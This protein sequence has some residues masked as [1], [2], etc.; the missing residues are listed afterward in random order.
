M[1]NCNGLC[2]ILYTGNGGFLLTLNPDGTITFATDDGSGY[3]LLN[4]EVTD[5]VNGLWHHIAAV[6]DDV[7]GYIYV[8]GKAISTTPVGNKLPPLNVDN[9]IRLL[10][11]AVDQNQQPHQHF[12]GVLG[13]IR[14]WNVARSLTDIL[15]TMERKLTGSEHGLVG[16]WP[17]DLGVK[18]DFS[19]TRN[20]VK[21]PG[22]MITM[23]APPLTVPSG[24]LVTLLFAGR[25][26]TGTMYGGTHGT[27]KNGPLLYLTN[28]DYVIFNNAVIRN[29]I[30]NGNS[31]SWDWEGNSSAAEFRFSLGSTS[32]YY[33]PE[34]NVKDNIF[35]GWV[36]LN[37][38]EGKLDFRG[39]MLAP[40][41]PCSFIQSAQ[42]GLIID[43]GAATP[44]TNLTAQMMSS[45]THQH[46]CIS[47]DGKIIHMLSQLAIT[48][49]TVPPINGTSLVLQQP[50][51]GN[52]AQIWKFRADGHIETSLNSSFVMSLQSI[53]VGAKIVLSSKQGTVPSFTQLWYSLF[54]RQYIFNES[55]A[56]VVLDAG[57]SDTPGTNAICNTQKNTYDA[58]QLWYFA[59]GYIVCDRNGMVLTVKNGVATS[60]TEVVM[61]PL[62][63]QSS[64][65]TWTVDGNHIKCSLGNFVLDTSNSKIVISSPDST[66]NSQK[67]KLYD[68]VEDNRRSARSLHHA[69]P[70]EVH[71]TVSKDR[72]L[73]SSTTTRYEV[74]MITSNSWFAGT[75]NTVEIALSSVDQ[76]TE[77]VQLIN[78]TTHS[79]PFERGQS[80]TFIVELKSIGVL[81]GMF[82]SYGRN[83]YFGT[84]RWL[85]AGVKVYDPILQVVY[86]KDLGNHNVPFTSVIEFDRRQRVTGDKIAV[87]KYPATNYENIWDHTYAYLQS[88]HG[89]IYFDA[90]GGHE[91]SPLTADI[92]V[93]NATVNAAVKMT[94]GHNIDSA[95][96]LKNVYGH[97]DVAGKET[98]GI[99]ASGRLN[100]DGQCHNIINRLMYVANPEKSFDDIW[101]D[102][103]KVP[104]GY[105]LLRFVFGPYG[106]GFDQWCMQNGFPPPLN[107]NQ[108]L[109]G[110]IQRFGNAARDNINAIIYAVTNL[111]SAVNNNPDSN[112]EGSE[113]KD[114]VKAVHNSG[115]D[116]TTL[117][118]M[119]NLT[120][121]EIQHDEL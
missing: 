97:D 85:L 95:H 109:Y 18:L 117:A 52:Q 61:E 25:Y 94:T 69:L 24:E 71:E 58:G 103:E 7:N 8:D 113:V 12:S 1:M 21:A 66:I 37:R 59:G 68:P 86:T 120:E 96:P 14:I 121:E 91:G 62:R 48:V 75:D 90:A 110:Y 54:G 53:S 100:W 17:G 51:S 76:D 60:G 101:N 9:S 64:S 41:S 46:F 50:T 78:S 116:N 16:Y 4:S 115:V 106:V 79:N 98:C 33:W 57:S 36:Q 105:G 28:T 47:E 89:T 49:S 31:I 102:V 43:A 42:N 39:Q 26:Q 74:T 111:R 3:A 114:F 30:F 92:L 80:D 5:V 19:R 107:G 108:Q 63:P 93:S 88:S 87:C 11:G 112:P 45:D 99:R 77:L 67:W 22:V 23:N 104:R 2:Y 70:M 32:R 82:L 44:G 27:W 119:T 55:G 6:R 20:T 10:I 118:N 35:E 56:S 84:E 29:P 38:S 15:S 73:L 40:M 34:A 72:N 65:Q 13:E 83:D 81:E